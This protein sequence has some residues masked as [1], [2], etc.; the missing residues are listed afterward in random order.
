VKR[1]DVVGEVHGRLLRVGR[2]A[3]SDKWQERACAERGGPG[4]FSVRGALRFG[5]PGNRRSFIAPG[6]WRSRAGVAKRAAKFVG[7]ESARSAGGS[8]NVGTTSRA[9]G[10]GDEPGGLDGDSG[11]VRGE[12]RGAVVGGARYLALSDD[13]AQAEMDAWLLGQ[14]GSQGVAAAGRTRCGRESGRPTD[15]ARSTAHGAEGCGVGLADGDA[16]RKADGAVADAGSEARGAEWSGALAHCG[17]SRGGRRVTECGDADGAQRAAPGTR[18]RTAR[19]RNG[20][21]DDERIGTRRGSAGR[22]GGTVRA[23]SALADGR[24]V[25]LPGAWREAERPVVSEAGAGPKGAGLVTQRLGFV[26]NRPT[27]PARALLGGWA[28][29]FLAL[30]PLDL[31]LAVAAW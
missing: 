24:A 2:T 4:E 17:T 27:E 20:A 28:R 12:Y 19:A 9:N 25:A 22:G 23:L 15:A 11:A 14:G 5:G 1:A 6:A 8:A 16:G 7:W 3:D 10:P 31:R 18:S 29:K 13:E 21:G 26:V 30:P